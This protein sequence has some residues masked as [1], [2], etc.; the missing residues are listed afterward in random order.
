[1]SSVARQLYAL[2]CGLGLLGS[3]ATAASIALSKGAGGS[4]VLSACGAAVGF[5]F[6]LRNTF[7][8]DDFGR[9]HSLA[10]RVGN[11]AGAVFV[12]AL[13]LLMVALGLAVGRRW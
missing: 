12:V 6:G 2:G 13:G 9:D 8:R 3:L 10:Y 1:V 7:E 11:L 4:T 5:V